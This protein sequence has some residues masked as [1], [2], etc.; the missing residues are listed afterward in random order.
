VD[1]CFGWKHSRGSKLI[2]EVLERVCVKLSFLPVM[3]EE[4]ER[5]VDG[6]SNGKTA[7]ATS[8]KHFF[9]KVPENVLPGQ[10]R[11]RFNLDNGTS[12]GLQVLVP[13]RARAGDY[14]VLVAGK[15]GAWK[16]CLVNN[17]GADG[18]ALMSGA[19]EVPCEVLAPEDGSVSAPAG[20]VQKSEREARA[21]SREPRRLVTQVPESLSGGDQLHVDVGDGQRLAIKVPKGA[22]PGQE[23]IL[24][25][26]DSGEWRCSLM[27]PTA[28]PQSPSQAEPPKIGAEGV[29]AISTTKVP[30]QSQA[31]PH[32]P[33]AGATK[34]PETSPEPPS[35]RSGGSDQLSNTASPEAF[36][37]QLQQ[38]VTIFPKMLEHVEV[39][40][41]NPRSSSAGEANID[42][43]LALAAKLQKAE[44]TTKA[45][46][47][48][49][50]NHI[51][52]LVEEIRSLEEK[53]SEQHKLGQALASEV[54]DTSMRLHR[55]EQEKLA[56]KEAEEALVEQERSREIDQAVRSALGV[57]KGPGTPSHRSSANTTPGPSVRTM[58]QEAQ[59]QPTARG[60]PQQVSSA[61]TAA[62]A[63]I[64]APPAPVAAKESTPSSTM[65]MPFG[66]S[67]GTAGNPVRQCTSPVHPSWRSTSPVPVAVQPMG[68][69]RRAQSPVPHAY[70]T[71]SS[72]PPVD[73]LNQSWRSIPDMA[74][75]GTVTGG[76]RM[77]PT[78][79]S[80]L[81]ASP[82]AP[83]AVLGGPG[84]SMAGHR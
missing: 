74:L 54:A 14:L 30:R 17:A 3:E 63:G 38:L 75:P 82:R 18:L 8:K 73:P 56:M 61:K 65:M 40:L 78:S 46:L 52:A 44:V 27:P 20:E 21:V 81:L 29:G 71:A 59:K 76:R 60:I 28:A 45:E 25:T 6:E 15:E 37:D 10:S 47:C 5:S 31:L 41:R 42:E 69:I 55:A 26:D 9:T 32:P 33:S 79:S 16:S 77:H 1:L 36:F 7:P 58:P 50:G 68:S 34:A 35:V 4:R 84:W 13:E 72:P 80:P 23:L 2:C 49:A 19:T 39:Q 66:I 43:A 64:A 12:S 67:R 57:E 22:Q 24:E 51:E 83:Q 48:A 70:V 11:L 53:L 62:G